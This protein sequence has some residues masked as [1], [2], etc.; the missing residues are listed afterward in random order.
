MMTWAAHLNNLHSY[1]VKTIYY[2]VNADV[3][4][5]L[6]TVKYWKHITDIIFAISV[7]M[8]GIK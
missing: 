5:Y 1:G 7:S 4:M 6:Y 2:R 8:Q 3:C